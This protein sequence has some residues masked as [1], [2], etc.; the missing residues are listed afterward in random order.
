[1]LGF[2]VLWSFKTGQE[3]PFFFL[4]PALQPKISGSSIRMSL[5]WHCGSWHAKGQEAEE[6]RARQE[7]EGVDRPVGL[8]PGSLSGVVLGGIL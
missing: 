6:G 3:A 5:S 1:L 8:L 4:F 2:L 7:G